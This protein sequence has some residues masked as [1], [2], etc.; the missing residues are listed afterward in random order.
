MYLQIDRF[1]LDATARTLTAGSETYAIRPKTL[2]LM[3]FLIEH[4]GQI[5]SKEQ[6]LCQI[7]DDV[8]V[9]E[10]VIFQSIREIRQIFADLMVIQNHPR[11]GYQWVAKVTPVGAG[12][13]TQQSPSDRRSKRSGL[14][15]VLI[16]LA[17][18]CPLLV[19]LLW[20]MLPSAQPTIA[21]LPVQNYVDH[22]D[23]RWLNSDGASQLSQLL[24]HSAPAFSVSTIS[25][26]SQ[27]QESSAWQLSSALYGD[28]YDY[29]L[30]YALTRQQQRF[31][32]VVFA[33]SIDEAMQRLAEVTL[34]NIRQ[35]DVAA[36]APNV[37]QNGDFANAIIAYET[38]WHTAI[39]PLERYLKAVPAS[40]QAIQYLSRLYIWNGQID[41]AI[42]LINSGLVNPALSASSKAELL[43]NLASAKQYQHP[44]LA[45]ETIAQAI[46]LADQP[47]SWLSRAKLE[48]LQADIYYQQNRT[49]EALRGY[50]KAQS[51]YD[52]I[53]ASVKTAGLQLKLAALYLGNQ[54]PDMAKRAFLK[55]K[56]AIQQQEMSFLYATLLEFEMQHKALVD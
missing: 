19:T 41:R 47:A 20:S 33:P 25:A 22:N 29:K 44:S 42:N 38:D 51:F 36:L 52:Q 13:T 34:L 2:A 45:L 28:E 48:E 4:Q 56:T 24:I 53:H 32:G 7:W 15:K 8:T 21:V 54:Q 30:V 3:L 55:A 46:A 5:V 14:G 43:F 26:A 17:L 10:G 18:L 1:R 16:G 9:N 31:A 39:P 11:K 50:L 37:L 49:V 23:L 12:S 6:L 40:A 27:Q 35:T